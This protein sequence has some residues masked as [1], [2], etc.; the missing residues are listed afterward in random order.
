MKTSSQ[1]NQE[2]WSRRDEVELTWISKRLFLRNTNEDIDRWFARG[3][4]ITSRM[5]QD[6]DIQLSRSTLIDWKVITGTDHD[7]QESRT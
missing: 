4:V 3:S 2:M 6:R 7:I 5:E 1:K